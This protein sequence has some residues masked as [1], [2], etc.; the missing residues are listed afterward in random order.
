M[1]KK[2]E[3]YTIKLPKPTEDQITLCGYKVNELPNV[4]LRGYP[5]MT[6]KTEDTRLFGYIPLVTGC[7]TEK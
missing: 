2:H 3:L 6:M 7:R 5:N 1:A 4:D